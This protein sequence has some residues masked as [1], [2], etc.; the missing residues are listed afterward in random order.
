MREEL[1]NFLIILNFIL[2]SVWK[3]AVRKT[4]KDRNDVQHG[5]RNVIVKEE[6]L[7]KLRSLIE[8]ILLKQ[9]GLDSI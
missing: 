4:R 6:E 2:I 7:E 8:K 1:E 9:V 5:R 3:N